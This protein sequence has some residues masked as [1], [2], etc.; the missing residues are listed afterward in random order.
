MRGKMTLENIVG[1]VRAQ[2]LVC[3]DVSLANS[4]AVLAEC[5][6]KGEKLH[7]AGAIYPCYSVNIW[8]LLLTTMGTI[9]DTPFECLRICSPFVPVELY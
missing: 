6:E 7:C 9:L 8:T 3:V 5:K 1:C 4:S 2:A